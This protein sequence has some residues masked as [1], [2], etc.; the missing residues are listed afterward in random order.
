MKDYGQYDLPVIIDMLASHTAAFS[1][2]RHNAAHEWELLACKE[3]ILT[4]QAEI[5]SRM[6][7][8]KTTTISETNINFSNGNIT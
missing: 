3:I 1:Q 4:L 7:D 5:N 2:M 6:M 8:P